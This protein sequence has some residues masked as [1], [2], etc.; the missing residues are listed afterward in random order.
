M[1]TKEFGFLILFRFYLLWLLCGVNFCQDTLAEFCLFA[2]F[3][4]LYNET[5]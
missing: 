1:M 5:I 3:L 2:A 4:L